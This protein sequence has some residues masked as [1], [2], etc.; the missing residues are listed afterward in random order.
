M[1]ATTHSSYSVVGSHEVSVG[2]GGIASLDGPHGL[3][4]THTHTHTHTHGKV[5]ALEL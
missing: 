4:N 2:N 5:K 1:S 3:T